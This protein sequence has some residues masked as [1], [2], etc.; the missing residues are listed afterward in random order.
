M[1]ML[2]YK[3]DNKQTDDDI[4]FESVSGGLLR[5]DGNQICEL[6]KGAWKESVC[7][8]E[9]IKQNKSLYS[10]TTEEDFLLSQI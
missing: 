4:F 8:I 10:V 2:L 6:K 7:T 9:S 1:S 5:W 3:I